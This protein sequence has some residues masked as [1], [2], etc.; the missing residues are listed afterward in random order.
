VLFGFLGLLLVTP[1]HGAA[2]PFELRDGDRVV[3]LGSTLIEREQRYGYWETALT[4]LHPDR[5]ITFRNLGW[6]GD[7]VWGEARAGFDTPKEGYR[8]LLEQTF[9][10]QPTVIFLGYGTNESFAGAAGLARF[11][12][13]YN[14][15]LDDLAPTKARFVLLAPVMFEEATWKG[16]DFNQRKQ[17]LRLY[18]QAINEIADRRGAWFVDDVGPKYAPASPLTDNGMHLTAY[19]YQRTAGNLLTELRLLGRGLHLVEL[20]GLKPKQVLQEIL[21]GPPVPPHEGGDLDSPDLVTSDRFRQWMKSK[22]LKAAELQADSMVIARNLKSGRYTLQ[23]DG[24]AVQTEDAATWMDPPAANRV[25]VLRGPSL[26]QAEKLRQAIAEKNR[27][28]FNRWRPQNETYLFGFRK[29]EQGQNARE[30]PQFDPLVAKLEA[31]IAKLRVPVAH[32]Y[33][34]V[35]EK[36]P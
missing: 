35:P 36:K 14:K 10:V 32:R 29:H 28:Y 22:G 15:L 18:T 24:L 7:T 21:P 5:N 3:L 11:R 25:F 27:L 6:S 16:G 34:L 4:L 20:D 2:E 17:D 30:I 1:A 31:E 33:E 19:G 8:R 26:D 23:I 13:Q 9:S 12:A